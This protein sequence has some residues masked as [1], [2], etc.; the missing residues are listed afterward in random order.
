MIGVSKVDRNSGS[1]SKGIFEAR[2]VPISAG[3]FHTKSVVCPVPRQDPRQARAYEPV[4]SL[5][6]RKK[7][8][9]KLLFNEETFAWTR[10]D[11]A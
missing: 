1:S 11:V 9:R 5:T 6:A 7:P 10:T 3:P 8:P 4:T 2:I